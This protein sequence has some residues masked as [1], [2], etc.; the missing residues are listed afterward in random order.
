MQIEYTHKGYTLAWSDGGSDCGFPNTGSEWIFDSAGNV[1][2]H[3]TTN[4]VPPTEEQAKATIDA[5]LVAMG[6]IFDRA[7]IEGKSKKNDNGKINS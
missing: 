6:R 5:I 1:L 7:I 4:G 3:V 2:A